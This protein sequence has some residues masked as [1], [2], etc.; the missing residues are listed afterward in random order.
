MYKQQLKEIEWKQGNENAEQGTKMKFKMLGETEEEI[1]GKK[2]KN[3]ERR[4]LKTLF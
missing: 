2:L 3:D 4:L 1:K